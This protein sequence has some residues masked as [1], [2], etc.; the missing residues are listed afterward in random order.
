MK[1]I[2]SDEEILQK[3]KIR[4][5]TTKTI[6]ICYKCKG[7]G[8]HLREELVSYHRNEYNYFPEKCTNCDGSGLVVLIAKRP[9]VELPYGTRVEGY[10]PYKPR[11]TKIDE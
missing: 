2:I 11:G 7:S 10:E 8:T 1:P 4:V 9:V 5:D 3:G 6:E